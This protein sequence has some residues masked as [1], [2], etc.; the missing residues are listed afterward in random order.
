MS[1]EL[2]DE[3]APSESAAAPLQRRDATKPRRTETG[4]VMPLRPLRPALAA[5]RAPRV[6]V[7]HDWL[8]IYAGAERVLEQILACFPDADLFSVVDFVD[9]KDRTFLRGK[10]AT[11]SF[12]QKLPGARK[13]YRAYLP[14]MPLAIEQLDVS[15]YDVVISSS[16]A[17]AKGVLTGP[18]QFHISYVHS[19][20]R[21]AWDLQH[22]YLQESSL[23]RGPKSMLAR[24]ILHYIRNWDVRTANSVD[25]F[26]ANSEFIARRI[27]KVYQRQA[28]VVY[29]PVDIDAFELET[30]KDDFYLTASRLVPYK[31][32]DL[33][34]EAF[35]RMP[36]RRLV[37]IGDGPDMHKV[38]AKATPNVEV[39]GYQPFAVL[40]D[41]MRR[42]KAFVFAAEEDFG[43]SVV[44][45]QACGTPVIAFGK[46]GALETVRDTGSRPTGI[47]FEEQNADAIIDAVESF[48]SDPGRFRAEDCRANA[49]RFSSRHFREQFFA[50]VA[51]AVPAIA[52]AGSAH[53]AAPFEIDADAADAP[54][55]LAIDQSGVLG[56][57][58]LSLLEVVKGLR[59][60]IDV[61]LFNDGP[62]REALDKAGARV[63]V[64]DSGAL[65]KVRRDGGTAPR[66]GVLTGIAALVRETRRRAREA[67]VLY[68]N[69][70]RAMVIG[71]LAG[72]LARKPVVWHLRDIVSDEHFGGVQ[73]AVIKGCAKLGLAHVIANS[74]ASAKV[75]A[76]LTRFDAKRIDVV[77][78]G[79]DE[80]PFRSLARVPQA[81]LRAQI[82]LPEDAFLVGA[83]SR[84]AR[85]KGQHVLLEALLH[86]PRAH[87]VFVGAPLFGEDAY[88]A[89]LRAF[90]E[91]NGLQERVHFLGFRHDIAA[92]MRA[93][94]VIAHTSITPEPFGRVVVEGMLA[95]RPVVASRDGGVTEIVEH[96]E[97]GLLCTPGDAKELA[98]TI[99]RLHDDAALRD[100][101]AAQGLATARERFGKQQYVD[102]V[103]RVL[104]G[105]VA[106]GR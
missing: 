67:D 47:F 56:G 45:A 89:E 66:L 84:L 57:A 106:R 90:V 21:Y 12:I 101:L 49:E 71:V 74:H 77:H 100:G 35:A 85:W 78:N 95:Q 15:G 63:E 58:E 16:H 20:I 87:A 33:I 70:Q 55:V 59:S 88:A 51:K 60:R 61:L 64:L 3:A 29:P 69:T 75:F 17:V 48:E 14:F 31:K 22:Q 97:S 73:R 76:Q 46:G 104:D 34:V 10:R 82:G 94:D 1:H 65:N 23:T 7:V 36:E 54:R 52:Q 38:R 105:V 9:A 4:A 32:I 8:V 81:Q 68:A 24:L 11:T 72:K 37:V 26:V 98:A 6:A 86:E 83:F 102:A 93:V 53:G 25:Q 44:E 30:T 50:R 13:R 92:C 5:G 28:E 27:Q 91:A 2:I 79:V 19:P 103:E 43:I 80:S 96:G 41:R 99:G 18:D 62:F 40:H 39:L 42:A